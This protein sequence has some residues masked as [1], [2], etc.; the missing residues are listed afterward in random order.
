MKL[1]GYALFATL[2]TVEPLA[3]SLF[4]QNLQEQVK[5]VLERC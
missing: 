4:C 3:V 2:C 5:V 1:I